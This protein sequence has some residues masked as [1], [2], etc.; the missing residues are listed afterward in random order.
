VVVIPIVTPEEMRAV[1]ADAP[2]PV[3][4]LIE[5]AGRATARVALDMLG[6]SYGRV[7]TVV[8]GAGNNGADGRAAAARLARRGVRV[9]LVDAAERQP[10]LPA[11]DLVIDAAYGTGFR[12]EWIAPETVGRRTT[13]PLVLAVDIPSGVDATTGAAGDG[14]LAADRTVT[15]QALKPGLVFGDGRRFAGEVTV[16]DIGL[17]VGRADRFLVTAADVADWLPRR[18]VDAHKWNGAVR[19]IAG[20]DAMSGAARLCAD[21]AARSG[22]GL[23]SLSTPGVAPGARSE[24]VQPMVPAEGFAADVLADLPRFHALAI[25]PGLGREEATIAGVRTLIAEASVPVVVDGDGLF[26]A[27]W[28]PDD[29]GDLLAPRVLPTVVTPHDG[30]YAQLNGE[31]PAADRIAAARELAASL[32]CTVLL[33]G[34]TTVVA[35][36][37]RP[38]L[39]IDHGDARLATAGS[40]DVLT[41]I[42]A[43][44]LAAAVPAE[45]AA[46]AAAWV[47]AEAGRRGP[48]VGLLAGDL[49]EQLPDVLSE[50]AR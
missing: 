19:V 6:A 38:T 46:A 42:I 5:R 31:A 26:A 29:P 34:P 41:G 18:A 28:S 10:V 12:G 48:A 13:R 7:V 50:L 45:R 36:P 17:D 49:V 37:D 47:H 24:I 22:A 33:K 21:G 11:S 2:E 4:E 40:G 16:V 9:H 15:F 25:G 23:V 43:A 35:D 44:F 1:D 8:A 27:A 14:V 30:E 3:E 20:S 39:V 32:G